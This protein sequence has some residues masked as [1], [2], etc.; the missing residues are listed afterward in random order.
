MNQQSEG[1]KS[2]KLV[3]GLNDAQKTLIRESVKVAKSVEEI[4]RSARATEESLRS[5]TERM[6]VINAGGKEISQLVMMI[7]DISDKINLL[8]LNAAIEAARAGDYGRGFAVVADEIGKLAQATSDNSKSIAGRVKSIITDID[9]GTGLV[10]STRESTDV[11]FSMVGTISSGID[12]VRELMVEQN[13]ALEMVVKQTDV[14]ETRSREVVIST[15]EQKNS[16]V[17]SMHTV[18]RL[19]EMA[20]EI[21]AANRRIMDFVGSIVTNSKKLADLVGGVE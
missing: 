6:G 18:E 7:D 15:Q 5:M 2:K 9:E 16:M 21:A 11:I 1:E 10:G 8:S 14:I 4:S 13:G 19:A 20:Q 12:A 3:A 17:Q